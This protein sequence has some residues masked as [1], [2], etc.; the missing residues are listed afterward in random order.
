MVLMVSTERVYL[1]LQNV[2]RG[3]ELENLNNFSLKIRPELKIPNFLIKI[4]RIFCDSLI[5]FEKNLDFDRNNS[6]THFCF[7]E[8]LILREEKVCGFSFGP[9][10]YQKIQFFKKY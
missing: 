9:L 6:Y 2:L 10:K 1:I 7:S 8:L 4:L 3:K 5:Q